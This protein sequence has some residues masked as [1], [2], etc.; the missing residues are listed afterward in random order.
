MIM[1][2][3]CFKFKKEVT[4]RRKEEIYTDAP[5][6]QNVERNLNGRQGKTEAEL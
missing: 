1:R 3:E 2:D 5:K 4:G 6:N